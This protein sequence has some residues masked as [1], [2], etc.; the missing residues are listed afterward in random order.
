MAG[1]EACSASV[2]ELFAAVSLSCGVAEYIARRL[3]KI[4]FGKDRS[5]MF[6][7]FVRGHWPKETINNVIIEAINKSKKGMKE[8]RTLQAIIHSGFTLEE[9][10][11][12][13]K[14][15]EDVMNGYDGS[16][17]VTE[18]ETDCSNVGETSAVGNDQE[19][20]E[21]DGRGRRMSRADAS[22]TGNETLLERDSRG[23]GNVTELSG[24]QSE[25]RGDD[26]MDV[27]SCMA[28]EIMDDL[29]DVPDLSNREEYRSNLMGVVHGSNAGN[30]Q[31]NYRGEK[32][33]G[34]AEVKDGQ[35]R[36]NGGNVE[37]DLNANR[38]CDDDG[39][40]DSEE[41]GE[42]S[43]AGEMVGFSQASSHCFKVDC[44]G[45]HEGGD[46]E[47]GSGRLQESAE[48]PTKYVSKWEHWRGRKD[49]TTIM[50][51][52]VIDD[53]TK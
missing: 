40:D 47:N 12:I 20:S 22:T 16:T 53:G 15:H 6:Q 17:V 1:M 31:G 8:R 24:P 29:F 33:N 32:L 34:Q 39:D 42:T 27:D 26:R 13:G 11:R 9:L 43:A 37:T 46:V 50:S 51:E 19:L 35:E 10:N 52:G 14:E 38:C 28:D 44:T 25:P 36:G 7:W 23:N 41:G 45:G 21:E 4:L 5:V 3:F 18:G 30:D 2:Q 49:L 48:I